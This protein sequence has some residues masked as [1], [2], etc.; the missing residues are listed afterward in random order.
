[1]KF[2]IRAL[3]FIV[4]LCCNDNIYVFCSPQGKKLYAALNSHLQFVA[5]SLSSANSV[6]F[7]YCMGMKKVCKIL[8]GLINTI[9]C[10]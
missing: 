3:E 1:M 8:L 10:Y 5:I 7:V 9:N 2:A 4:I 6:I